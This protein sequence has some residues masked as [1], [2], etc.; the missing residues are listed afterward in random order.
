MS[1]TLNEFL[2]IYPW[3]VKYISN[4]P[5]RLD[6]LWTFELDFP[7]ATIW[8]LISDT[9]RLNKAIGLSE[10]NF[11]E[12]NGVLYGKAINAGIKLE[13][14]EVPWTWDFE[15][16]LISIRE[17]SK[18]FAYTVKA[19]YHL[20]KISETSSR[21]YVY[22]GWIPRGFFY[23]LL[24][25]ASENV[26]RKKY[27]KILSEMKSIASARN[28]P[29]QIPIREEKSMV[30]NQLGLLKI[31]EELIQRNISKEIIEKLIDFIEYGNELD[32]YRIRVLELAK[33]WNIKE[34][35]L[36]VA[37]MYATRAGLLTISWDVICPHCRGTR[38]EIGTL[39]D[40]PS[41]ANC[42]VC[43]IEY[44]NDSENSIEITFHVHPSIRNVAKVFYCSAEPAKKPHIKFQRL[45]QAGE[46]RKVDMNLGIGLYRLRIKGKSEVGNLLVTD[47]ESNNTVYWSIEGNQNYLS[48]KNPILN[49][50]NSDNT[51]RLFTLEDTA[52][53]PNL[54][55]PAY[56]FSLQ[57][58]HDLFS[59][60]SISSDLKLELGMQTVLFT[61]IVGSSSLYE[62]HGD[63]K[64]FIKVKK[65]FEEINKFVKEN[66]GA[67]I[68]TIGDAV[69]AAFPSPI[70]AILAAVSM[71]KSFNGIN[72]NGIRLR[73]SIHYGQCIAVNLNSGIDFFGKT[74]NIAAKIQKLAGVSQIVFTKEF[75]ENPDVE[76]FLE[77][78]KIILE[79]IKYEIPGMRDI[80]T[81]YR[82]NAEKN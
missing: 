2:T 78:N 36:V 25:L 60:E 9:S 18:G 77:S 35:E 15:K 79:E 75:K 29:I 12:V 47:A 32:L 81:I 62:E 42:D 70:G 14:E 23:R 21:L 6:W 64:T 76:K 49:I 57:E 80:F 8:T 26:I 30:N 73:V 31:K 13:W 68:K 10:M 56:I 20:E 40:I 52:W 37:C 66:E 38:L 34:R 7:T 45:L 28:F 65:H 55:R 41:K 17:Y 24:L 33:K 54:L 72:I 71:L 16:H 43:D 1:L 4:K 5:K 67:I 39:Y 27:S 69:M 3:E 58:F 63:S 48:S 51:A 61:D 22:L 82:I 74:V 44:E 11:E 53:D 59:A 19:I 46:S 50:F